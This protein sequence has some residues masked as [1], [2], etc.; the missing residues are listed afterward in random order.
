M[1]LVVKEGIAVPSPERV[2]VRHQEA[3]TAGQLA[4]DFTLISGIIPRFSDTPVFT[5][6]HE[7]VTFSAQRRENGSF[8]I[9]RAE[10]LPV[11]EDDA[12]SQFAVE[13]LIVNCDQ[14]PNAA[15]NTPRIQYEAGIT[16]NALNRI[17]DPDIALPSKADDPNQISSATTIAK[18]FIGRFAD[19]ALITAFPVNIEK[20]SQKG[21]AMITKN[22]ILYFHEQIRSIPQLESLSSEYANDWHTLD[23]GDIDSLT[24]DGLPFYRIVTN[25][26]QF[27]I[28]KVSTATEDLPT[29]KIQNGVLREYSSVNMEANHIGANTRRGV[30][31]DSTY[32]VLPTFALIEELF[33]LARTSEFPKTAEAVPETILGRIAKLNDYT[34]LKKNEVDA[35]AVALSTLF[36]QQLRDTRPDLADQIL[37]LNANGE[38]F[39]SFTTNK[40]EKPSRWSTHSFESQDG[41]STQL[42][43]RI[44][45]DVPSRIS[46]EIIQ[47]SIEKDSEG[48]TKI[49]F[50]SSDEYNSNN[51]EFSNLPITIKAIAKQLRSIG[52][53]PADD[54]SSEE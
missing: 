5:A 35:A 47:I 14:A 2:R 46:P 37:S 6:T 13:S 24:E 39:T 34:F 36:E 10:R 4:H 9:I 1:T 18:D 49:G 53:T 31:T 26:F 15:I 41:S 33:A 44:T 25:G 29:W 21:M 22:L 48:R 45:K 7:D 8:S 54:T 51:R 28:H 20:V 38:S 19:F 50:T 52:G 11:A 30:S 12:P 32:C 3:E 23:L 16:E 40:D 43:I 42:H 27:D 17:K